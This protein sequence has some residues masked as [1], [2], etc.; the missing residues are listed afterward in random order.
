[1]TLKYFENLTIENQSNYFHCLVMW[2]H[3]SKTKIILWTL[4]MSRVS[5]K[6]K[7]HKGIINK[8]ESKTKESKW[9]NYGK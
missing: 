9:V 7:L 3:F 8:K 6:Y 4:P 1:M 5:G 2:L